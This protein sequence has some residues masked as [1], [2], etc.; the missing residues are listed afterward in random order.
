[1]ARTQKEEQSVESCQEEKVRLGLITT[2]NG[3]VCV[4]ML[5]RSNPFTRYS[6]PCD[7]EVPE[8]IA[9]YKRASAYLFQHSSRA[10]LRRVGTCTS[11]MS[12]M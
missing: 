6:L 7:R 11:D 3:F 2:E 10:R 12:G 9:Q 5:K 8:A 1:M 4:K